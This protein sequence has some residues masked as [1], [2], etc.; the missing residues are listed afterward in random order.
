MI[1]LSQR[2]T[3]ALELMDDPA[4]DPDALRRTY[5]HFALVNRLVSGWRSTYVRRLRP[6]IRQRERETGR[7]ATLL[8]VGC[9][10]G[11]VA[12]SLASWARRD[13]LRLKVTGVD[14]DARAHDFAMSQPPVPCLTFERTASR[15]LVA[16]GRVFDLVISNHVVHHLDTEALEGLLHDSERLAVGLVVHG[17]IARGRVAYG[18]YRVATTGTFR[19]SFIHD[20]GLLSIRRSYRPAELQAVVPAGWRVERQGPFRVLLTFEPARRHEPAREARR[21]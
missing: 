7:P 12:R 21:A 4:C 16:A 1:D 19:G 14:P 18:A 10:G 6:L 15:D 3:A 11:D 13:G 20:D 8:D 5:Q 9:G 2:E 17:D